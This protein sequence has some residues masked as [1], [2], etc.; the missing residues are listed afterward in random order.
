[1]CSIKWDYIQGAG[2]NH[3]QIQGARK[4]SG[5]EHRIVPDHIE[6]GT[7]AIAAACNKGDLLIHDAYPEHFYIVGNVLK[8]MGVHFK[9]VAEHTLHLKPSRLVSN[10]LKVRWDYGRDSPLI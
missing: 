3:I 1:M 2:T 8:R 10:D 7:F 4:L 5:F 9:F 6:T